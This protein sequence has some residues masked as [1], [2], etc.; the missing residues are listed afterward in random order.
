MPTGTEPQQGANFIRKY[1][2][3]ARQAPLSPLAF[4][5]AMDARGARAKERGVVFFTSGKDQPFVLGK[6]T[7]AFKEFAPDVGN[8]VTR[9][10][11]L[12]QSWQ[13]R[14]RY[15]DLV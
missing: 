15:K 12:H 14:A 4:Y 11:R 1:S 8:L 3:G 2:S 7:K 10:N 5:Q 13:G 6:Y 9:A